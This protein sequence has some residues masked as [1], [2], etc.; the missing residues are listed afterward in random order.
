M[1][2]IDNLSG[3]CPLELTLRREFQ[4][5]GEDEEEDEDHKE[6]GENQDPGETPGKDDGP[7]KAEKPDTENTLVGEYFLHTLLPKMPLDHHGRC[8][9]D[10]IPDCIEAGIRFVDKYIDQRFL[11][12]SQLRKVDR[13]DDRAIKGGEDYCIAACDLNEDLQFIRD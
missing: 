3:D 9:A 5:E 6:P 13:T 12:C 7:L 2:F 4:D 8:M 10:I 1:T 11:Q